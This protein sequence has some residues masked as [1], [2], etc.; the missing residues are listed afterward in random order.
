[1]LFGATAEE[2]HAFG[3]ETPVP[4]TGSLVVPFAKWPSSDT[5]VTDQVAALIFCCPQIDLAIGGVP[6]V[7]LPAG[8]GDPLLKGRPVITT[9]QSPAVGTLGDIVLADLGSYVFVDGPLTQAIS[10]DVAFTTDQTVFRFV[11]RVDG[12]P[13]YASPITAYKGGRTVSPF[14]ALAT[15]A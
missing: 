14:I 15:R 3:E 10:A 1:L 6:P 7:Y 4:A 2:L 8:V 11:W 12:Q 5:G 13:I 9:E